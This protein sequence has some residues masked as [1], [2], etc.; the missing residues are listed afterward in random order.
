MGRSHQ[1]KD[2]HS[3]SRGERGLLEGLIRNDNDKGANE[4]RE[5]KGAVPLVVVSLF[6]IVIVAVGLYDGG[7]CG[8]RG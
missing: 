5:R 6:F 2:R 4:W 8:G 7:G 1:L 3:K